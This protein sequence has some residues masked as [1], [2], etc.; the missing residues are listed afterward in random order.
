MQQSDFRLPVAD[1]NAIFVRSFLPEQPPR[2]IVQL[3]HGMA[4]HSARYARFGAALSEHGYGLYANDHRGHG[5]TVTS[6]DDLGHYA[7]DDGWDKVVS[8]QGALF[9]ELK[10]RHPRTPIFLMG[11]SMGSYIV[12]SAATRMGAELAGL[13]LSGTSHD[14]AGV[15]KTFRLA[16]AAERARLG[17]RGKSKLL[18]KLS[19]DAFN[20]Q[21]DE[22]RTS[23]DWLSRDEA[24]VDKYVADPL[25]GF[26]CTTQLWWDMFGGLVEIYSPTHIAKLP[27]QLPIYILRAS[28]T[29][30]TIASPRSRSYTWRSRTRSSAM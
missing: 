28:A 21:F 3:A 9:A 10:S 6:S 4:E 7:D 26:E 1:G 19:F 14:H 12:R 17:K 30:S 11:H 5:Y 8:D 2:A 24:E 18:R 20:K 16:A 22:P 13:V 23:A 27:K 15:Y 25:C 29:R